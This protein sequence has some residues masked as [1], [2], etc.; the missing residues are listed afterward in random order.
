MRRRNGGEAANTRQC[1][2]HCPSVMKDPSPCDAT[3]G[4][5][6]PTVHN[7]SLFATDSGNFVPGYDEGAKDGSR[8]G[9]VGSLLHPATR[10]SHA[11]NWS[12]Y[13]AND[14]VAVDSQVVAKG[15]GVM[16]DHSA[17]FTGRCSKIRFGFATVAIVKSPKERS[18]SPA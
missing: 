15:D 2:R 9:R 10:A 13:R 14:C 4:R 16:L 8:I 6:A 12:R 3:A 17:M 18:T 11:Q 5:H 7:C 1:Y